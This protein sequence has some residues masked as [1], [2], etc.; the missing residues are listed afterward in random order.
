MSPIP[1]RYPSRKSG[2]APRDGKEAGRSVTGGFLAPGGRSGSGTRGPVGGLWNTGWMSSALQQ[3]A[4]SVL[5]GIA[6]EEGENNGYKSQRTRRRDVGGIR[7]AVPTEWGVEPDGDKLQEREIGMGSTRDREAAVRAK[8]TRRILEGRDDENQIVDTNG[9]YKRRTSS[10]DQRPSSAQDEHTLVYIHHVQPTDTLAG[11]VLKYNCPKE[12]FKK[13]NG[14]WSDGGL[15]FR[16]MVVL[17]VDACTVKGKSCD[18]PTDSPYGVD[19]LAPTPGVEDPPFLNGDS[20]PPTSFNPETSAEPPEDNE[21][22]WTHVRWVLIDS[23]PS[24]K[25]VE[26]ARMSRKALG[27]FPPRRRKSGILNSALS[28]PRGSLDHNRLSLLSQSSND[29]SISTASTPPRRTSNLGSQPSQPGS[30]GSYFPNI[31]SSTRPRRESVG[32]AADRLG[33]MRGPG[34]VGTLGPKIRKPGPGN[35]GLNQWAKKHFALATID[36]HSI[37][38]MGT[39]TAHFGFSDELAAIAEGPMS[40]IS[41]TATPNGQNMGLENAA[42]AVEGF[43]RK[44]IVNAPGTPRLGARAESDLIELLDGAGSDDGKGFEISPGRVRS[45]TPMGSGREDLDSVMRGRAS[46]GTKG[47]KSD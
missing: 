30:V 2:A 4:N 7:A 3:V 11:V 5:G 20:W 24:S 35:D 36:S 14:L 37:S 41:G 12:V 38:I 23:S 27:Y 22:P 8:K 19:L 1:A 43:F 33:W 47:G 39:D 6:G 26:I 42:A 15:P 18:P 25:P 34:G 13:A 17:P 31:Q 28:T 44:L 9:N 45:S 21:H 32:E 16:K 29:P 10:D 40:G 46:A